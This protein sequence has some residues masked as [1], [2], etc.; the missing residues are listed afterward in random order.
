MVNRSPAAQSV[1]S[2]LSLVLLG[3]LLLLGAAFTVSVAW[4][5]VAI[6]FP[7]VWAI[8]LKQTLQLDL[9]KNIDPTHVDIIWTLRAPRAVLAALVGMG[10]SL[11]GVAA[12]A[13]VRNPL[14]DPYVLGVSAGA[15]VAAVT[16]ILF[17]LG[18]FGLTSTSS[19]AFVGAL[20]AMILVILF[21]QRRGVI[22]PLRLILAGVAIGQLLAGIT[23]FLVLQA[24]DAHQVFGVLFWLE[25]SLARSDWSFLLLPLLAILVGG[26]LLFADGQKLNALLVGDETAA[27]LGVNVNY[28]RGRLLILT[29]LLTAVMVALSG[30]IGFVGLVVP[31]IARLLVGSDHRRVLPVA[32]LFG[33]AFLIIADTIARLL[34][35]PVEIPVGIVTG[36]FGA[37]FFLWLLWRAENVARV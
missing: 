11:A 23:S 1:R 28:L 31:H 17:G 16:S 14:A 8:L 27:S 19:A 3:C 6:P 26:V 30:I 9:I 32:A 5:A 21:G 22:A 13:L 36:I 4:G 29:A 10:L 2:P 15:S 24:D 20:L 7:T 35:A 34:L 12:Q 25:G 37:P 18:A 33:A